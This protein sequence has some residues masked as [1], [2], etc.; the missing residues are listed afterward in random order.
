[1]G[2]QLQLQAQLMSSSRPSVSQ[3][4]SL[5]EVLGAAAAGVKLE[6]EEE[7][8]EEEV[9]SEGRADSVTK[10]ARVC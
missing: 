5:T 3:L 10:A 8:E 2:I 6:D 7:G 9:D 4:D 1:M